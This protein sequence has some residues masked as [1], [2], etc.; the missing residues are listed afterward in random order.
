MS[1]SLSLT[2][3]LSLS[4]SHSLS[5]SLT[6]S[7]SL[8][9]THSLSLS[10]THTHNDLDCSFKGRDRTKVNEHVRSHLKEKTVAC[11]NCGS[12]FSNNTKFSDH[13]VRQQTPSDDGNLT[14]SFCHKSFA[15]ERLLRD[16]TRRH[17]NTLQCPQCELTC[18]GKSAGESYCMPFCSIYILSRD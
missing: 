10:L 16:H 11:S 2:L 8:S 4:L 6:H 18:Q 7:L 12:V 9:L 3:S 15:S 14:C 5:L 17:I 13:L 1:L